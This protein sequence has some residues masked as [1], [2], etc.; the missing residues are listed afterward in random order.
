MKKKTDYLQ[1]NIQNRGKT[2]GFK[3]KLYT[4]AWQ[5]LLIMIKIMM[6]LIMIIMMIII[7]IASIGC[8][9]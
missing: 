6:I 3:S 1:T 7:I 4:V 8:I 2:D 5:F 9:S